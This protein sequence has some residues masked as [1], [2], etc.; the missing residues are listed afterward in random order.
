MNLDKDYKEGVQSIN[1]LLK[2]SHPKILKGNFYN[3]KLLAF[4]LHPTLDDINHEE[5]ANV[6]RL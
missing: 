2:N 4:S 3:S 1:R 5:Q 6:D